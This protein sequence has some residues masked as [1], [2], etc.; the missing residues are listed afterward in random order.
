MYYK[1][2]TNESKVRISYI[3]DRELMIKLDNFAKKMCVSR[4]AAISFLVNQQLE[5]YDTVK[6]LNRLMDKY[7]EIK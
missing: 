3:L 4:N 2:D 7:D 5:A 1:K 6:T